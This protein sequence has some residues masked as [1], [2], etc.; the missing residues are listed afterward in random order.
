MSPRLWVRRRLLLAAAGACLAPVARA[1]KPASSAPVIEVKSE[2]LIKGD[3]AGLEA[4]YQRFTAYVSRSM[5]VPVT[6]MV[7]ADPEPAER[8][9]YSLLVAPPVILKRALRFGYTPLAQTHAK[10]RII[11]AVAATTGVVRLQQ[12]RGARLGL[13]PKGSEGEHM[14]RRQLAKLAVGNPENFFGYIR[15]ATAQET[16]IK[17]L[18]AGVVDLA[19]ISERVLPKDEPGIN[20]IF[21]STPFAE[22]G[23]AVIGRPGTPPFE[24][25]RKALF[26]PDDEGR[27]IMEEAG[28]APLDAMDN[29]FFADGA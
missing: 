12:L 11:F 27:K 28:L 1:T 8:D 5:Q 16:A 4:R 25:L 23:I 2:L 19:A 3:V 13:P 29:S 6:L 22:N 26:L 18:R 14:A 24:R 21:T 9:D 10:D 17:A 7:T 20:R 15:Y